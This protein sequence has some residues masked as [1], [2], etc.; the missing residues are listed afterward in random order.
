[1]IYF[2]VCT[3]QQL[4]QNDS[5]LLWGQVSC[6]QHG[7]SDSFQLPK[8]NLVGQRLREPKARH[9]KDVSLTD[10]KKIHL[11]KA[12]QHAMARP[13]SPS[14]T[15][16]DFLLLRLPGKRECS[17]ARSSLAFLRA[18]PH[19]SL[20]RAFWP[21][22]VCHHP[23]PLAMKRASHLSVTMMADG[24]AHAVMKVTMKRK[25][26]KGMR[27]LQVRLHFPDTA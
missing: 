20:E 6:S 8:V 16:E 7:D 17:P 27:V 1:M 19:P 3:I 10:G 9:P 24:W 13:S 22:C 2:A 23:R 26:K 4:R 12:E 18:L 11:K 14:L 5:G 21:F 25:I 15:R